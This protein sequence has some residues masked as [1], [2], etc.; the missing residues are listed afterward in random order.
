MSSK[1]HDQYY[2]IILKMILSR[3]VGTQ[4]DIAAAR[5]VTKNSFRIL[6]KCPSGVLRRAATKVAILSGGLR[7]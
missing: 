3:D 7:M 2:K 1:D 6:E 5:T 4:P